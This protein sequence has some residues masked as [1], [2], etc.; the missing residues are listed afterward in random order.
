MKVLPVLLICL[1]LNY[2]NAN[3]Q[4]SPPGL[5]DTHEAFWSAI[6]VQQKINEKT[7]S[8]TYFGEGRISGAGSNDMMKEQSILVLNEEVYRAVNKNWKYSYALS[9][10]RQDQYG[11]YS[12]YEL[13]HPAIQQEFRVYGRLSNTIS[14]NRLKWKNTIRQEVRKFYT[15]DFDNPED[16]MQ[17]RTRLKAQVSLQLGSTNEN[18]LTGSAEAL[19]SISDE[20]NA[21]WGS[22]GY[23]E[24]RFC[25]YYSYAPKSLPVTFDVGY[26]NDLMGYGHDVADANYLAFDIIL[27]NPF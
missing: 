22:F 10:R 19:F 26:M 16:V 9:Y 11:N 12:P 21:G 20:T 8:M 13:E 27:E 25:F 4:L 18:R 5:G 7:T 2:T 1:F 17:L 6:G 3:A 15:P 14:V 23:K 24:S